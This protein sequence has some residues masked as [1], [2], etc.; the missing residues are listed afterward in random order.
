MH[1][2]NTFYN[3][4]NWST[5]ST[6]LKQVLQICSLFVYTKYL[7]PYD[8]G[9]FAMVLLFTSI[10]QLLNDFG[11]KSLIVL[12]PNP[13]QELKSTIYFLNI[14]IGTILSILFFFSAELISSFYNNME[15]INIIVIMSITFVFTSSYSIQIA[16]LE[17]ELKFKNIEMVELLSIVLSIS[18][19]L[20][21]VVNGMGVYS[22]V[23]QILAK[24]IISIVL[25]WIFSKWRPSFIFSIYEIQQI[26]THLKNLTLS[27]I[28][29][30]IGK[31]T[32][33]ILIG[34]FLSSSSLGIYNIAF[35]IVMLPIQSI[36]A[37]ILKVTFP[38]L[39]K[40][41][42]NKEKLKDIYLITL[43]LVS[44]IVVPLSIGLSLLSNLFVELFLGASWSEVAPLISIMSISAMLQSILSTTGIILLSRGLTSYILKLTIFNISTLIIFI[45][46]GLN[47]GLYGVAISYLCGILFLLVVNMYISWKAISL[48]ITDGIKSI[49]FILINSLL[50]GLIIMLFEPIL[51][52]NIESKLISFILLIL[53]GI[54]SYLIGLKIKYKKMTFILDR[55]K[56]VK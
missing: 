14:L 18:I 17:K 43:L 45:I 4:I 31:N 50:M 29:T 32:D 53:I 40:V 16:L 26:F 21:C 47:Y 8:F 41:Q 6:I 7:T 39:S 9:L 22:L 12:H 34:K 33:Q 42:N 1:N 25:Y 2:S 23:T 37:T 24:Q 46:I 20:T 19:G 27:N 35:R 28:I 49:A 48:K 30:A 36:T 3:S 56:E 13:S 38:V 54:L 10:V 11:I 51:L 15:I 52:A 44:I 55:I 5:Y